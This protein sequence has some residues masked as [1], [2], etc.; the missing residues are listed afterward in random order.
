MNRSR[1]Q[2]ALIL[3]LLLAAA[4]P[5]FGQ[6]DSDE[7]KAWPRV[8]EAK[9]ATVTMYEPQLD[10]WKD[11]G[12][13]ARAAVSVTEGDAAPVFGAVWITGRFE[14][15]RDAR[16][17]SFYDIK[18]PTVTF[19]EGSE[20]HQKQLAAFLEREIPKWDL[21]VE[22][23]RVIPLLDNAEVALNESAELNNTPPKIIIKYKPAVL[24]LIDGQPVEAPVRAAI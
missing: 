10:T 1:I 12:F 2:Y 17:V 15:D 4:I 3:T 7:G 13:E 14:V 22:L 5:G 9:T 20:E 6:E 21:E 23:D 18:I 8:M 24:I 19:P 16:M 11:N